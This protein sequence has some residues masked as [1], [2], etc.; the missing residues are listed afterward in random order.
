ML[1][2]ARLDVIQSGMNVSK[3]TSLR[4]SPVDDARMQEAATLLGEGR[5]EF[6]RRAVAER[7]R[8]VLGEG[9]SPSAAQMLQEFIGSVDSRGVHSSSDASAQFLEGLRKKHEA[10]QQQL[11]GAE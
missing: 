3:S 11:L 4:F 9:V 8:L 6:I 2:Y 1:Y 10:E 7:V 5:S